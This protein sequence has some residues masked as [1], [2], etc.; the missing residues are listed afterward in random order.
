MCR[1]RQDAAWLRRPEPRPAESPACQASEWDLC[2]RNLCSLKAQL[3]CNGPSAWQATERRE[4]L[5]AAPTMAP[6][7]RVQ[8]TAAPAQG[9][10]SSSGAGLRASNP[11][12]A[13]RAPPCGPCAAAGRD[14]LACDGISARSG[15]ACE[16]RITAKP[17]LRLLGAMVQTKAPQHAAAAAFM[18]LGRLAMATAC[19]RPS[20]QNLGTSH[21]MHCGQ[22]QCVYSSGNSGLQ[23]SS[24]VA[25]L[26]ARRPRFFH[27]ALHLALEFLLAPSS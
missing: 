13:F 20:R 9:Q 17:V 14:V 8:A 22:R 4:R 18:V 5:V 7:T 19:V 27:D 25:R 11:L 24:S 10:V 3:Q 1:P 12:V 16:T 26:G 15:L 6:A 21:L 2:K 23:N